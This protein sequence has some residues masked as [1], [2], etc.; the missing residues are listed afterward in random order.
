M[1]I[2]IS[3]LL[4]LLGSIVFILNSKSMKEEQEYVDNFKFMISDHDNKQEYYSIFNQIA[5]QKRVLDDFLYALIIR[6]M[7]ENEL[8]TML[9]LGGLVSKKRKIN[10]FLM[11][12]FE[13]IAGFILVFYANEDKMQMLFAMVI[14]LAINNIIIKIIFTMFF[15]NKE[16]RRIKSNFTYFLDL[17]ATATKSGMTVELSLIAVSEYIGNMSSS[18][19]NYIKIYSGDLSNNGFI[20]AGENLRKNIELQEVKDFTAVLENAMESGA[21]VT[22]ALR[23]LSKETREFHFIETEEQIGKI[24]AKMGI[25]LILFIMFPII[26]EIIAPGVLNLVSKI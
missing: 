9:P 23:E 19:A 14:F 13:I 12:I 8:Y 4:F 16:R 1:I 15:I 10:F 22:E 18:L 6:F 26:V 7:S 17:L 24:N 2:A 25:P 21:A 5:E 11:Y 20:I 3:I